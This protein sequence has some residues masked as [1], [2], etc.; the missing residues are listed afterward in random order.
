MWEIQEEGC[1][2]P[3]VHVRR[4]RME[5]LLEVI[6]CGILIVIVAGFWVWWIGRIVAEVLEG[7]RK[8]GKG[9]GEKL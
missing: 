3:D 5:G 9:E 8:A 7:E 6:Q 2:G 1:E 4:S